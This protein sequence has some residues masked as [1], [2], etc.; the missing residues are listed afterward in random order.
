[1]YTCTKYIYIYIYDIILME[2][3]NAVAVVAVVNKKQRLGG[4]HG[5]RSSKS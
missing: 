2:N 1:M 4:A 5:E 3:A